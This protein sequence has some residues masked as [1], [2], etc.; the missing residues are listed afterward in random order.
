MLSNY[1]A[2]TINYSELSRSFGISDNTARSYIELLEGSFMIRLLLP[3]YTNVGKRIV[4]SPKLYFLDTGIYHSLLSLHSKTQLLSNNKLGASWETFALNSLVKILQLKKEEVFFYATH[5]GAEL[6]LL[7]TRNGKNWG[8]EF[9]YQDAPTKSRSMY[10][11]IDDLEL[12]HLFVVYPGEK[13]YQVD[14]KITVLPLKQYGSLEEA[15]NG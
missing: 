12:E 8:I 10:S 11:C 9:K 5:S 15:V 14:E 6:D 1:N 4:K 7:F 3:Y 13:Q 2:Q